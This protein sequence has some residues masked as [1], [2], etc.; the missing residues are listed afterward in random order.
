MDILSQGLDTGTLHQVL[1]AAFVNPELQS[2]LV[3]ILILNI[4]NDDIVRSCALSVQRIVAKLSVMFE[5][6]SL[7]LI[8]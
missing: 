6:E 8:R 2:L 1:A 3:D 5:V 4:A 7:E